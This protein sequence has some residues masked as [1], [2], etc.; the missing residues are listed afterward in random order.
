M[1]VSDVLEVSVRLAARRAYERGRLRGA[2]RRGALAGTFAVPGFVA[3]GQSSW[4]VACL[5]GFVLV[6]IAA[7]VRGGDVDDGAR[8]GAIAG[9][10]PCLLP[11]AVRAFDPELCLRLSGNGLWLCALGGAAAGVVLA[12]VA[13]RGTG[14]A[15]WTAA[16]A[17]TGFAGSIGCLPAGALGFAG[18]AAGLIAGG[19]PAYVARRAAA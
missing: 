12:V 7:R 8:A 16:L 3:C 1:A 17:A 4:A 2:L 10:L 11:A 9:V 5:V 19:A 13:R 15:F 6:V 18:L 14:P